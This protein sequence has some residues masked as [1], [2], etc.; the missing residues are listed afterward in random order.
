M[1]SALTVASAALGAFPGRGRAHPRVL[2][3][4]ARRLKAH[5]AE[6]LTDSFVTRCGG[7]IAIIT[8]HRPAD[9]AAVQLLI[10][11]SLEAGRVVGRNLGLEVNGH[12]GAES[13]ASIEIS[14]ESEGALVFITDRAEPSAWTPLL[15]RVLA[16]P[17][18]TPRLADDPTMREG[19]IFELA[20]DPPERFQTPGETY[21][22]LAA[23]RDGTGR[24]IR[25]VFT[26]DEEA[27]AVVSSSGPGGSFLVGTTGGDGLPL[28]G[29]W[30]RAAMTPLAFA[31][32]VLFPVAVCDAFG[33]E[34]DGL[35]R[36]CCLGF[37][38]ADSRLVGPADLFD[39]PAFDLAR[40]E[41][42]ELSRL[43]RFL[44]PIPV[45]RSHS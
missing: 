12:P 21:T 37:Q 36:C 24:G 34:G 28:T 29:E 3:E 4:V 14:R 38:L 15:C 7:S 23:L 8:A 22:L 9:Q 18:V 11:E 26:P 17:F 30:L 1:T 35:S 43:Q 33:G 44:D 6:C 31:R 10:Q 39:D 27:C 45:L 16:D 25:R 40:R 2:E 13:A 41:C 32:T 5:D 42:Q 20:G 19:F